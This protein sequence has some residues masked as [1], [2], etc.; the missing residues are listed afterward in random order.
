MTASHQNLQNILKYDK[1]NKIGVTTTK[2][3]GGH[4]KKKLNDR[5]TRQE[6]ILTNFPQNWGALIPKKQNYASTGYSK[7]YSLIIRQLS[8]PQEYEQNAS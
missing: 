7:N 8:S 3:S 5:M 1:E 4:K 2:K 6:A